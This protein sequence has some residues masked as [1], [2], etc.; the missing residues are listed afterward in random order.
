VTAN[1]AADAVRLDQW[2]WAARFFRTRALASRAVDGGKVDVN[3]ARAKRARHLKVGEMVRVRLGPYEH[4]VVVRALAARRGSA[5]EAA[6]LYEEEPAGRLRRERLAEQHRLAR[7]SFAYGEG[8]PSK[9]ERRDLH[10]LKG[11]D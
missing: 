1:D 4:V 8:K 6:K 11:K 10:R 3:G 2:L 7:Q 9:R 5:A